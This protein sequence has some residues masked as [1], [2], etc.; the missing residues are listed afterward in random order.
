MPTPNVRK[1]PTDAQEHGQFFTPAALCEYMAEQVVQSGDAVYDPCCGDGAMLAAAAARGANVW[2]RERTT[3]AYRAAVERLPQASLWNGNTLTGIT[4]DISRWRKPPPLFDAV[5]MNPP[6]GSVDRTDE[7]QRIYPIPT[8]EIEEVFLQE[9]ITTLRFGGRAALICS[10]GL[11][12][13]ISRK[14]T[15][16]IRRWLLDT[17]RI[18]QMVQ[19]PRWIWDGAAVETVLLIVTRAPKTERWW[20]YRLEPS[21]DGR[22]GLF[23]DHFAELRTFAPHWAVSE[24]SWVQ[25]AVRDADCALTPRPPRSERAPLPTMRDLFATLDTSQAEHDAAFTALA[26]ALET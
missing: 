24:R 17:C 26:A 2:G 19:L 23:A 12:F 3:H 13:R 14:S 18:E 25:E 8:T 4:D 10:A 20:C 16:Q 7:L 6:M 1:L 15:P 11:L 21:S 22:R 5:L 9:A